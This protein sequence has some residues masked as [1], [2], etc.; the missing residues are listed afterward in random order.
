VPKNG[1]HFSGGHHRKKTNDK[2]PDFQ[3]KSG[4]FIFLKTQKIQQSVSSFI[5][6]S[7]WHNVHFA[8]KKIQYLVSFIKT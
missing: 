8:A 3:Q 5:G 1:T 7:H 4:F 2:N 6:F